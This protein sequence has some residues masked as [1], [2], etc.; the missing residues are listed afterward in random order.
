MGPIAGPRKGSL[1]PSIIPL[2]QA[3]RRL[4]E[5]RGL[6]NLEEVRARMERPPA[7]PI[8]WRARTLGPAPRE[9]SVYAQLWN[10]ARLLGAAALGVNTDQLVVRRADEIPVTEIQ[11]TSLGGS[12]AA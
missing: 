12:G 9:I 6:L 10:E 1:M 5:P 3:L 2:H 4:P 7:E 11:E 8:R